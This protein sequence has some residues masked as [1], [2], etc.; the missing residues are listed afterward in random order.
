MTKGVAN[1]ISS[2]MGIDVQTFIMKM[3]GF[4]MQGYQDFSSFLSCYNNY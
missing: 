3:E 1:F 4:V 2:V